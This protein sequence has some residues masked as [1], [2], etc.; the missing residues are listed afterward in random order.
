MT[1]HL[2]AMSFPDLAY[3]IYADRQLIRKG[4][5]HHPVKGLYF[6]EPDETT[7]FLKEEMVFCADDLLVIVGSPTMGYDSSLHEPEDFLAE[8]SKNRGIREAK[9]LIRPLRSASE[10][11]FRL[12]VQ[13]SCV[14]RR[15]YREAFTKKEKVFVLF[16]ALMKSKKDFLSSYFTLREH[17]SAPELLSSILTFLARVD[18]YEDQKDSLSKF[19]RKVVRKGKGQAMSVTRA[20]G[21]LLHASG[22]ISLD[23]RILK[24]CFDLRG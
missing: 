14:L 13:R 19:Y 16:E 21:S 22:D 8:I 7:R 2:M 15:W 6:A 20:A 10:D 5:F 1:V 3:F 12:F 18:S 9:N 24:F 17:L 23:A 11:E 4:G